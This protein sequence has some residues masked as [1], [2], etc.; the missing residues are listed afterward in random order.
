MQATC[1]VQMAKKYNAAHLIHT[2]NIRDAVTLAIPAKDRA[3][4]DAPK[5]ETQVIDIPYKNRY[6]MQTEYGILTNSHPTSELNQVPAELA[7]PM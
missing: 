5:M 1:R 7:H 3:V 4:N 2:F 6:T